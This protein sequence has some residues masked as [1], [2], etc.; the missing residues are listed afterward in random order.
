MG[1]KTAENKTLWRLG[2][3]PF[4]FIGT[5]PIC[6]GELELE[7]LTDQKVKVGSIPTTGHKGKALAVRGLDEIKIKTRLTPQIRLSQPAHFNIDRDTPPGT[8][9]TEIIC[10]E[11]RE[12]AIVHVLE[13]PDFDIAPSRVVWRG[14]GGDHLTQI[15]VLRNHGNINHTLHE[16]GMIW[17][18][19]RDWVGRSFVYTLREAAEKEKGHQAF[20]DRALEQFKKSMVHTVQVSLTYDKADLK[21]GDTR[22]VMLA[23]TL[24]ESLKKGRTYF[25]FIKLM[26][27]RLWIEVRCTH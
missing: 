11:Q 17:L 5:P 14:G 25:G 27:K 8:Y 26:G 16:A 9:E 2:K 24:P 7:N 21:P 19:E 4:I 3:G 13:N 10:G 22:Q 12:P 23:I 18:E 15:L 1:Q 6:T 20:L